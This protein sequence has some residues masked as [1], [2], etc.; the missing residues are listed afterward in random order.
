[1]M[2][3]LVRVSTGQPEPQII[4]NR[5]HIDMTFRPYDGAA[6]RIITWVG[7]QSE[8][9]SRFFAIARVGAPL[10]GAF[11]PLIC[12][13]AFIDYVELFGVSQDMDLDLLWAGWRVLLYL[14]GRDDQA[15]PSD[16]PIW[17]PGWQ[18]ELMMLPHTPITDVYPSGREAQ[19][20]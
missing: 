3:T 7:W 16:L 10:T 20:L 1:M 19:Q 15:P 14:G 6:Y 17:R 5:S 13:W 11:V 18:A 4:Q 12:E 2:T 9:P 8:A